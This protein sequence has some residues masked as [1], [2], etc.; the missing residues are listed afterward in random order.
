[1]MMMC[2]T[3]RLNVSYKCIK[4]CRNITYGF[5]VIELTRFCD[6]QTD[7]HMADA[8]GKQQRW[9]NRNL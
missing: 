5:Q 6:G 3:S 7:R 4:F 1:M 8:K 9:G 2:M